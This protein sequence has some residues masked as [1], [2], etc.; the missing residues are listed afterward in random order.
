MNSFAS[1][2]LPPEERHLAETCGLDPAE[3]H[4]QGLPEGGWR[5][6]FAAFVLAVLA[7]APRVWAAPGDL[8]PS[9]GET[10][11]ARTVLGCRAC[12]IP[13]A[14]VRQDDGKLVVAGS[15]SDR[16]S[17]QHPQ[18]FTLVRYRPDGTR[19]RRFGSSGI[20]MT[21]RGVAAAE[22][23]AVVQQ[24][25]GKLVAAGFVDIGG[26]GHFQ[27]AFALVRYDVRGRL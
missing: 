27:G 14:V 26:P 10:G 6:I 20:V 9:F 1:Q 3:A 18:V 5:H 22:A 8:D 13:S 23:A 2:P 16:H 15:S 4:R 11:V 19:D 12:V 7:I 21:G 17:V 24:A 25:D